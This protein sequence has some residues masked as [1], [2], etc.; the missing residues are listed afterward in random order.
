MY[1]PTFKQ[2]FFLFLGRKEMLD[3]QEPKK[4][5]DKEEDTCEHYYINNKRGRLPP[6]HLGKSKQ[7]YWLLGSNEEAEIQQN[8]GEGLSCIH[9]QLALLFYWM[10]WS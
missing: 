9:Q 2:M 5:R 3:K 4:A 1:L 8:P 10:S 7:P 6:T